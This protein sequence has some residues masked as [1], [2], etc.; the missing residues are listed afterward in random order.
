MANRKHT[1]NWTGM[2]TAAVLAAST[3]LP[4]VAAAEGVHI[5]GDWSGTTMSRARM[6][7]IINE[8]T[9][10]DSSLTVDLSR[11]PASMTEAELRSQMGR[12]KRISDALAAG[13]SE[14]FSDNA[15]TV[16]AQQMSRSH[17]GMKM[18]MA[19]DQGPGRKSAPSMKKQQAAVEAS[20]RQAMEA[21]AK[22]MADEPD[23]QPVKMS[24]AMP[25]PAPTPVAPE[26]APTLVKAAP[27]VAATPVKAAP[28]VKSAPKVHVKVSDP[29]ARGLREY[30][31]GDFVGAAD[32]FS[33]AISENPDDVAARFYLGYS[34]YRLGEHQQ[35]RAAFVSA[36][37]I[38]PG[39][40]PVVPPTRNP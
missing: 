4:G 24:K 17:Q 36:Y 6:V 8:A 10:G 19:V 38:D 27:V 30:Y 31:Q 40:S 35:A 9:G 12:S 2:L 11:I 21:I 25:T 23:P 7:S 1:Y 15:S 13:A 34:H 22:A 14:A 33:Q 18:G 29:V 20:Q 32:Y 26:V 16:S 28:A 3:L 39:F 5:L 37:A